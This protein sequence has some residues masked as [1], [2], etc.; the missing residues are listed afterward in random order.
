MTIP[1]WAS[2]L[3][4]VAGSLVFWFWSQRLIG[5]RAFPEGRIGDRLLE[6]TAQ[7]G[8]Q[9]VFLRLTGEA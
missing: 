8:L 9:D 5:G 4:L 3:A 7:Y 6:M 2:R 1:L